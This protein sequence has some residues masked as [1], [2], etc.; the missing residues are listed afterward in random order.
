M[1][2]SNSSELKETDVRRCKRC[3]WFVYSFGGN[4]LLFS[5]ISEYLGENTQTGRVNAV[6]FF[7]SSHGKF[8]EV[9]ER[10]YEIMSVYELIMFGL[11]PVAIV[12]MLIASSIPGCGRHR[13]KWFS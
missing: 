12:V 5:L 13:T 8:T 7:L 2:D 4:W 1:S 9:S 6:Q 3:K 10:T 11:F